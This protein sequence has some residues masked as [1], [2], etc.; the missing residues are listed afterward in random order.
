MLRL[1]LFVAFLLALCHSITMSPEETA[2]LECV[3]QLISVANLA[4]N[5]AEPDLAPIVNFCETDCN[6]TSLAQMLCFK[7]SSDQLCFKEMSK[8]E[9]FKKQFSSA[10]PPTESSGNQ[11]QSPTEAHDDVSMDLTS[12]AW[13]CSECGKKFLS[14]KNMSSQMEGNHDGRRLDDHEGDDD[15]DDAFDMAKMCIEKGGKPCAP[16]FSAMMQVAN[17]LLGDGH[18]HDDHKHDGRRLNEDDHSHDDHDHPP[19]ITPA[20]LAKLKNSTDVLC[21][22]CITAYLDNGLIPVSMKPT[23]TGVCAALKPSPVAAPTVT[24]NNVQ[25]SIA[26]AFLMSIPFIKELL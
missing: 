4:F 24:S 9:V 17:K 15:G 18:S 8:N 19:E 5:A 7:D 2:E 14:M 23:L 20:L 6:K 12:M 11:G 3:F 1:Q 25:T 21:N 26:L 22:P 16:K 10:P 13:A